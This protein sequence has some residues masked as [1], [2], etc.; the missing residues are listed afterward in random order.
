MSGQLLERAARFLVGR[1][2]NNQC[3]ELG[4]SPNGSRFARSSLSP[5][6]QALSCCQVGEPPTKAKGGEV[7]LPPLP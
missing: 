5:E 4:E 6:T 7:R 1:A 3:R 2:S